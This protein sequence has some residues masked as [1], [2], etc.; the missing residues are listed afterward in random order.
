MLSAGQVLR[1]QGEVAVSLKHRLTHDMGRAEHLSSVSED[2]V[3]TGPASLTVITL[4]KQLCC[5]CTT[6]EVNLGF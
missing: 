6:Q 4:C 5:V 1:Q 2:A 3:I